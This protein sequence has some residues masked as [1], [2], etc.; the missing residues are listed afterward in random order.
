MVTLFEWLFC[1]KSLRCRSIRRKNVWKVWY[2][3][4]GSHTV[5][6]IL[7]DALSVKHPFF[8]N[9]VS[10]LLI[11]SDLNLV[12]GQNDS[13]H[14]M[15]RR[16]RQWDSTRWRWQQEVPVVLDEYTSTV[17]VLPRITCPVSFLQCII[18]LNIQKIINKFF[19]RNK[20]L[21]P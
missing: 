16:K 11:K 7:Q 9:S 21:Q 6:I 12:L 2:S 17:T 1:K 13:G 5:C 10:D 18:Y 20:R 19:K 15:K 8:T 14:K 4:A 3:E